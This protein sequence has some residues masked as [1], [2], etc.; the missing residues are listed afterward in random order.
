MVPLWQ[1]GQKLKVM[2][3]FSLD[4]FRQIVQGLLF[5]WSRARKLKRELE[6]VA[7]YLS[8]P[9]WPSTPAGF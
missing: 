1:E 2:S 6:E 7:V 3:A 8:G 4:A 9:W 5:L